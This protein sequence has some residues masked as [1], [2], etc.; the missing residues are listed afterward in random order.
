MPPIA[1]KRWHNSVL[2]RWPVIVIQIQA[3]VCRSAKSARTSDAERLILNNSAVSSNSGHSNIPLANDQVATVAAATASS[4]SS[5]DPADFILGGVA[6]AQ[7]QAEDRQRGHRRRHHELQLK[8][9]DQVLLL[10]RTKNAIGNQARSRSPGRASHP[11]QSPKTV[12]E[13]PGLQQLYQEDACQ[14]KGLSSVK[15]LNIEKEENLRDQDSMFI[16]LRP[17][18]RPRPAFARSKMIEER[19]LVPVRQRRIGGDDNVGRRDR[20]TKARQQDA[21]GKPD[22]KTRVNGCSGWRWA[23]GHS[24]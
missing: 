19:P 18:P 14:Q 13:Q 10:R 16:V 23:Y 1:G 11:A 21:V 24:T 9:P 12:A 17:Q 22:G 7:Q 3:D 6:I 15:E 20:S 2:R 5:E 8:A 4:S